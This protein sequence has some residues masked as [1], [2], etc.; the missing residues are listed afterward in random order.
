MIPSLILFLPD[1][2]CDQ[3]LLPIAMLHLHK[4]KRTQTSHY[5]TII[6]RSDRACSKQ[7]SKINPQPRVCFIADLSER[8]VMAEACNFSLLQINKENNVSLVMFIQPVSKQIGLILVLFC[9][10]SLSHHPT[11]KTSKSLV[12]QGYNKP[13]PRPERFCFYKYNTITT[14]MYHLRR[15]HKKKERKKGGEYQEKRNLQQ[16]VMP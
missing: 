6:S 8:D 11:T 5:V 13:V 4:T 7:R 1:A 2:Y 3:Q 15:R 10:S 16:L 14:M 12:L 9:F